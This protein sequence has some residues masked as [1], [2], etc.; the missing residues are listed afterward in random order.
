MAKHDIEVFLGQMAMH[1]REES[2][3]SLLVGNEQCFTTA[4]YIE[5]YDR[6][7]WMGK[8]DGPPITTDC[9][10]MHLRSVGMI[11]VSPDVWARKVAESQ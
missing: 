9:A 6:V 1:M 5:A 3:E 11:E 10:K 4:Q 7:G 8:K 2:V